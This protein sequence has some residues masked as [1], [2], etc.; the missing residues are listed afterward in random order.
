VAGQDEEPDRLVR[1]RIAVLA[2]EWR[3]KARATPAWVVDDQGDEIVLREFSGGEPLATLHGPWA[4]TV[5]RFLA[6]M[7]SDAGCSLAE[8]LWRIGGHG[9]SLDVRDAAVKLLRSLGLE[10][11]PERYRP[12]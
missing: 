7:D 1:R 12:G 10:E 5:G 11:R 3:A 8:L 6:A 9:G 2:D 4:P